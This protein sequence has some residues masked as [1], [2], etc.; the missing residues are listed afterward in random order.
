MEKQKF[1]IGD[2]VKITKPVTSAFWAIGKTG[3]IIKHDGTDIPYLV[4][5]DDPSVNTHPH[6]IW[7]HEVEL[8]EP[9]PVHPVIVITTDGKTVTATKRQGKKILKKAEARCNCPD[10]FNFHV[11]A[12]IALSRLAGARVEAIGMMEMDDSEPDMFSG[13]VVCTQS[14]DSGRWI[15]GKVYKVDGGAVRDELGDLLEG[16]E[17]VSDMNTAMER[18]GHPI[19]FIPYVE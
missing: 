18:F 9:R 19:R 14:D 10:G 7:S 15:A 5:I 17:S 8:L 2:R 11:G 12:L 4:E 3:F 13:K 1:R 16:V 6:R